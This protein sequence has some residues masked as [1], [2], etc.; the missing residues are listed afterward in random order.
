MLPRTLAYG[1]RVES[2]N[3]RSYRTSIQPQ[4]GTGTYNP[5]DTIII[6]IPTRNNLVMSTTES[7][8]KFKCTVTNGGNAN[9]YIRLDSNGAHV[10]LLS[11]F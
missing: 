10:K 2:S 3:A 11:L 5:N 1:S 8:L 6:N 9:I 7:F 4:N